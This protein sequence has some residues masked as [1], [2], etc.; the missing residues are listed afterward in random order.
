[1][2]LTAVVAALLRRWYVVLVGLLMTAGLVYLANDAVPPTYSATGSVLLL[3]PGASLEDGSNPL[4]QLG[5]LEQPAALVVAYLAGDEARQV[6]AEDFPNTTY[7]IVLDPL[8]RGPLIL[9]TVED[10]S[11]DDVM[12]ALN[13]VLA[14]L[15]EALSMLQ[16][17]VDAPADSRVTS[18]PLSVDREATTERGDSLRAL[19]AAAGFALVLTLVGAIA[20]DALAAR[21]RERR[22]AAVRAD[23]AETPALATVPAEPSEAAVP[24]DTAPDATPVVIPELVPDVPEVAPEPAPDLAERGALSDAAK[25]WPAGV[26]H[27][28]SRDFARS[29]EQYGSEWPPRA[30]DGPSRDDES[31]VAR[32]G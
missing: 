15:P 17:Q 21:R 12:G 6:F 26:P 24:E 8:S 32:R 18:M 1:M 29:E 13:S 31:R 22:R 11:K 14:T 30:L 23:E 25:T 28:E 5:G 4:L 7:D 27:I 2:E 20:F 10:P 16:D 19:I 9:I 3:P